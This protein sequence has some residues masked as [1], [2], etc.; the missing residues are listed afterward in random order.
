MI[1]E[2]Q[3]RGSGIS[4]YGKV[5]Q[6]NP[7]IPYS[8]FIQAF[9]QV[10]SIIFCKNLHMISYQLVSIILTKSETE[11]QYWRS[12]LLNAL[13]TKGQIII[14]VIP[15]VELIIGPQPNVS[16]LPPSENQARFH[17][18]FQVMMFYIHSLV[19]IS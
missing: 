1:N 6:I 12:K 2:A 8:C 7:D 4:I 3:R 15:D 14:N 5:D 10:Y 13:G 9:T 19:N 16:P 18:V 17:A 11:V